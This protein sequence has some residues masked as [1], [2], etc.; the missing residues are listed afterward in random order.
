MVFGHDESTCREGNMNQVQD[1]NCPKES[2][3]TSHIKKE[4]K[5]APRLLYM[6]VFKRDA[7]LVAQIYGSISCSVLG[8]YAQYELRCL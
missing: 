4:S 5:A 2:S 7:P 8:K 6:N 1:K 3:Q